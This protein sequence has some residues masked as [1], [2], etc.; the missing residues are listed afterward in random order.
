MV[1]AN[2]V[3]LVQ[4]NAVQ[5]IYQS[6][7]PATSQLISK[8]LEVA[9]QPAF[10][11]MT[12]V[13]WGTIQFV[14]DQSEYINAVETTLKAIVP[15]IKAALIS[16]GHQRFLLDKVVKFVCEKYM[17]CIYKCKPISEIG[18][19][20]MLL[21]THAL[22]TILVALPNAGHEGGEKVQVPARY[23]FMPLFLTKQDV[24]LII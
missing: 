2:A 21:D 22:K 17:E 19:E 8:R 23:P 5:E 7:I 15:T 18:A 10:T 6:L 3:S 14:G 11:A 12:R 20:Q 4:F 24:M 9:L 1:D 13:N 16:T